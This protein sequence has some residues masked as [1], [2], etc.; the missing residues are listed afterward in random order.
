MAESGIMAP[1][2]VAAA[3]AGVVAAPEEALSTANGNELTPEGAPVRVPAPI[4]AA[5]GDSLFAAAMA[6]MFDATGLEPAEAEDGVLVLLAEVAALPLLPGG[7]GG[8][9]G[10]GGAAAAPGGPGGGAA[11]AAGAAGMA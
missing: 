4:A 5:T 2:T 9:R 11:G 7:A 8:P 1:L 10:G 3:A 6:A